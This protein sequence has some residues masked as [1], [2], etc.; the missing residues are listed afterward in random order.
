MRAGNVTIDPLAQASP[1]EDP[2]LAEVLE[3]ETGEILKAVEF[4]G[5]LRYDA[6]VKLRVDV[7]DDLQRGRY[8]FQCAWCSTPAYIVASSQKHFFFRHI[9]EDGSCAA[10]TREAL[11]AEEILA[12]KYQGQRE[13]EP[14]KRIKALIERSLAADPSFS[15]VALE[16]SWRAAR[17][18]KTRRQPDVQAFCGER[19]FAF[20]VQ[21]STTFLSVVAGRRSFYRQEG[22]L[23]VW[24]LGHFTP[25][26]R[27]MT[28]DDLFFSN[29]SN[30][31]V[32]DEETAALSEAL[33]AFNVRCHYRR[34]TRADMGGIAEVWDE[35]VTPFR[36]LTFD[37]EGQRAYLYDF[38]AEETALR[39]LLEAEETEAWRQEGAVLR[40]EFFDLWSPPRDVAYELSRARWQTLSDSLE[41]R[42][43]RPLVEY[44]SRH[45]LEPIIR[46]MLSAKAGKPVGWGYKTLVELSH[47]LATKHKDCLLAFGYALNV[48]GHE[49]ILKAQD[50]TR[51]WE[52]KLASIRPAMG[53]Y[54]YDYLPDDDWVDL[55]CFLFPEVHEKLHGYMERRWAHRA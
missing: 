44:G 34:L 11:S 33:G 15:A 50:Q 35:R 40:S 30:V 51:R 26:Y 45:L 54:D 25:D 10:R 9:K 37:H 41:E 24:V 13:G 38:E 55:I 32:V 43:M 36:E 16:K 3:L 2:E 48:Y 14:H 19:R 6:L 46:S 22:G 53:N 17:D 28:T 8:R 7:Q 27:R 49:R 1:V 29:N 52:A 12:R 21:L 47:H 4:I 20:E 42:G 23:L 18:L 39:A 5:G 31:L